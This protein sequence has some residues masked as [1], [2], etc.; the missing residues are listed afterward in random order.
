MDKVYSHYI[1]LPAYLKLMNDDTTGRPNVHVNNLIIITPF[2]CV[3]SKV[4]LAYEVEVEKIFSV[5][6]ESTFKS[7]VSFLTLF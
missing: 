1:Y 2:I 4:G 6:R 3:G 5:L 7:K